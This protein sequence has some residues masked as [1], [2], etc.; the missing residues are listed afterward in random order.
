M[1]KLDYTGNIR[2]RKTFLGTVVVQVEYYYQYSLSSFNEN[3]A[4]NRLGWRDATTTDLVNIQ[5]QVPLV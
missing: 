1:N 3:D 4:E 5:S 2:Y